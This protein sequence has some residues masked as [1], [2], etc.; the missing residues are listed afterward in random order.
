M[1]VY[2]YIYLYRTY[3]ASVTLERMLRQ[4]ATSVSASDLTSL[5]EKFY[6]NANREVAI[7]CNHQRTLP[8]GHETQMKTLQ[9]SLEK[10]KDELKALKGRSERFGDKKLPTDKAKRQDAI[11]KLET[12]IKNTETKMAMKD[13]TKTVALGTSKINYMD[14]RITVAWCK[15]KELPLEKIFNKSLLNKFPWAVEVPTTWRFDEAHP[16]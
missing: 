2:M 16:I 7:L 6:T 8:K 4:G 1:Y 13:D 5:K 15:E 12:R 3:N 14:P 9:E 11:H 10:M